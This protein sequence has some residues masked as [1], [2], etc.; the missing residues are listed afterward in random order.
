MSGYEIDV[1]LTPSEKDLREMRKD[2]IREKLQVLESKV[3]P[4]KYLKNKG[5]DKADITTE[6]AKGKEFLEDF[7]IDKFSDLPLGATWTVVKEDEN[8]VVFKAAALIPLAVN[9]DPIAQRDPEEGEHIVTC[10]KKC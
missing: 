7:Q 8:C 1:P 10:I 5:W 3:D 9:S 2:Q 6:T 4:V